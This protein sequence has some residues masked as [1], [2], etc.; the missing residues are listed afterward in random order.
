MPIGW[1][2]LYKVL[3]FLHSFEIRFTFLCEN[4]YVSK[5]CDKKK[6]SNFKNCEEQNR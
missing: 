6:R 5:N 1:K 3:A 4:N 2:N